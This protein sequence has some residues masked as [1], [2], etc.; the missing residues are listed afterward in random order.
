MKWLDEAQPFIN[1]IICTIF[2]VLGFLVAT[3]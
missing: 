2:L 1:I 3:K